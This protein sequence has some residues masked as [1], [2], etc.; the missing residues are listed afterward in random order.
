MFFLASGLCY[1]YFKIIFSLD[2]DSQ[3]SAF[4]MIQQC[5]SMFVPVIIGEKDEERDGWQRD[6]K[7]I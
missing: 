2:Y 5:E 7:V 1:F 3:S 4:S 6:T